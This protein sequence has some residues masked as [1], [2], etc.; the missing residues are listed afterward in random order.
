MLMAGPAAAGDGIDGRFG[1][2]EVRYIAA[3]PAVFQNGQKAL[4]L[5][6][7]SEAAILRLVPEATKDF[8]LLRS[9]KPAPKCPASYRLLSIQAKAPL[10]SSPPF[11][12]CA[13]LAG[14]S[15]AGPYPLL[16]LRQSAPTKITQFTW[17]D[18]KMFELPA[19]TEACFA[20]HEHAVEMSGRQLQ[21]ASYVAAGEGRL[22]FHSAPDER[23]GIEGIFV[24]P[25]DRLEAS[26]VNGRY[27]LV[28][29]QHPKTPKVAAGWVHS[30]RLKPVN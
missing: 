14:I 30:A 21:Q 13:D 16:H 11:G 12:V 15:F 27:T 6:D 4:A 29:Y 24:V 1:R 3:K 18:G 20:K 7:A 17:K 5:D 2:T 26:R 25:G 28:F 19:M 9:W 22:Q 10:Q 23:C 8:I